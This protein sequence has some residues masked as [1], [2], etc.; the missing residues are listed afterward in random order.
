MSYQRVIS[1]FFS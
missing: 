1:C